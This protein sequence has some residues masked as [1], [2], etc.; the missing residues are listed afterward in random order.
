[1]TSIRIILSVT[2]LLI[3]SFFAFA[4]KYPEMVKVEGGEFLMG[5]LREDFPPA[6]LAWKTNKDGEILN[7]NL[8]FDGVSVNEIRK[9]TVSS[10]YVSKYPISVNQYNAYCVS[11]GFELPKLPSNLKGDDP[12]VNISW[13]DAQSYCRWLNRKTGKNYRLL[14]EAEWEYTS[15]GAYL[16]LKKKKHKPHQIDSVVYSE[17]M[18]DN[19]AVFKMNSIVWEW[20]ADLDIKDGAEKEFA[21]TGRHERIVRKGTT[22]LKLAKEQPY[23]RKGLYQDYLDVNTG[24]RIAESMIP[25]RKPKN[26]KTTPN[27]WKT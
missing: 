9:V 5:D 24:F 13:E 17:I 6:T 20:V 16:S 21:K 4:Q 19:D 22:G 11:M 18:L 27:V 12:M 3:S 14:T 26:K 25:L 15:G 23:N 10:F 7:F 2:V 8:K 1:M